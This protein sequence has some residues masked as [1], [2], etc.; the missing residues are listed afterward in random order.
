MK[1]MQRFSA[2][3]PEEGYF[4]VLGHGCPNDIAGYSPAE[5]AEKI[6]PL[7][8]GQD[9]R[10]LSCQTGCP[11]GSFAQDLANEMGVRVM[12]PT[13]DIGASGSGKALTV[14]DGGKWRWF[15][16]VSP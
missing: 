6:R 7:S 4:D 5:V 11:R 9:I 13:T 15:D 12:A 2:R 1:N 14:F 10:L 3:N 8:G 16:P